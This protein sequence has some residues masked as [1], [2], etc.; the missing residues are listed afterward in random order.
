MTDTLCGLVIAGVIA[1]EWP[2][3]CTWKRVYLIVTLAALAIAI[4]AARV[5]EHREEVRRGDPHG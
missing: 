2:G 1:H 5:L 4:A 3:L